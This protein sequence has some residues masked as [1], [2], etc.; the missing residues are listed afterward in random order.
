MA[1]DQDH[2]GW[3][4]FMDGMLCKKNC[5]IQEDYSLIEDT[6]IK[7]AQWKIGIIL[8]PLKTT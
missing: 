1:A 5:N 4:H 2:I 3:R 7:V 6:H 8:K